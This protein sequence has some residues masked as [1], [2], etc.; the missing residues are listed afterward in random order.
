MQPWCAEDHKLWVCFS[1][2]YDAFCLF[3]S[4][5]PSLFYFT[6]FYFIFKKGCSKNVA[7]KKTQISFSLHQAFLCI[8]SGWDADAI[9]PPLRC[10][11]DIWARSHSPSGA[12]HFPSKRQTRC[13][14]GR[15]AWS[16]ALE[17][18]RRRSDSRPSRGLRLSGNYP[19]ICCINAEARQCFPHH[20]GGSG[21][22]CDL[23]ARMCR[24]AETLSEETARLSLSLE[25]RCVFLIWGWAGA[26]E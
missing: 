8:A 20:D 4:S 7:H 18:F 26:R 15:R 12:I 16:A 9:F 3:Q 6:L 22:R 19:A 5:S 14:V 1:Y 13:V 2:F 11:D 21:F 10:G 24:P 25:S 23:Y 17:E